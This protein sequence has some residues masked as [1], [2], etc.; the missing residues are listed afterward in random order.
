[1]HVLVWIA[2]QYNMNYEIT[3]LLD[4]ACSRGSGDP[5]DGNN[6]C[7]NTPSNFFEA[8]NGLE[9]ECKFP[10]YYNGVEY[11]ECILYEEEDFV[12]PVFRC[13][14]RD[15]TTKIDGINSFTTSSLVEGHC[16]AD[17]VEY[18]DYNPQNPANFLLDPNIECLSYNKR[19]P[20]SQCKNNCRGGI[21]FSNNPQWI[22]IYIYLYVQ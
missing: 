3:G 14:I 19:L 21:V 7:R 16:I 13:P 15:V 10:F 17:D 18:D 22:T 9:E 20:F 5:Q 8:Q 1:M 12:Y 6:I 2:A 4:P 11:N